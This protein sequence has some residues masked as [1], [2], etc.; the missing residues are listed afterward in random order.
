M[1]AISG[2]QRAWEIRVGEVHRTRNGT[3]STWALEVERFG[4]DIILI[5][6][7]ELVQRAA[8]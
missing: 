5:N 8:L 4:G 7:P 2:G 3:E 1:R 6:M